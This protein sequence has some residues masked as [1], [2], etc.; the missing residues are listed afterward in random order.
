MT[1]LAS[2]RPVRTGVVDNAMVPGAFSTRVLVVDHDEAAGRPV[3]D[4]LGQEGYVVEVATDLLDALRRFTADPHDVVVM[5]VQ[6]PGVAGAE[7]SRRMRALTPVPVIMATTEGREL[8][9]VRTLEFGATERVRKPYRLSELVARI[10]EVLRP[11]EPAARGLPG[12]WAA[13]SVRRDGMTIGALHVDFAA[14]EVTRAGRSVHLPRR[15]FDLLALLLSPPGQ[16]RTRSELVQ[17]LRGGR[18]I[19]GSRTL[20]T[21]VRRLRMK[22]EEDPAKPR[23]LATVRGVG[24]RFD[25]GHD[26]TEASSDAG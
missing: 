3:F 18:G 24:F 2:E 21:H 22:L 23:H 14:R 9:P 25:L 6:P 15:E 4:A 11:S 8:D 10:E 26:R 7:V 5:D 20:D 1:S 13:V 19:P 16:L 17:R 12:P